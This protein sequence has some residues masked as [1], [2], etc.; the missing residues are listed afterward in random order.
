MTLPQRERGEGRR[1]PRIGCKVSLMSSWPIFALQNPSPALASLKKLHTPI[2]RIIMTEA[3]RVSHLSGRSLPYYCTREDLWQ[4]APF[5]SWQV[6]ATVSLHAA[7]RNLHICYK[8]AHRND[9][10]PVESRSSLA[11]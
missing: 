11:V 7:L 9:A 8:Q 1:G 10:A 6:S 4:A 3:C 5:V 2:E